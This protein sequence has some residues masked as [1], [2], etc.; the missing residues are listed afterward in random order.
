MKTIV[1]PAIV[2]VALAGGATI[3]TKIFGGDSQ[4]NLRMAPVKRGDLQISIG[5]SGVVQPEEVVDIG[6]QVAGKIN[7]LGADP[8]GDTDSQYK[9]KTV[10]F[11]TPVNEGMIL[12]TIDDAV[13][14]AVRDQNKASLDRAKAD[15]LQ[16]QAKLDQAGQDWKRAERLFEM[17][18]PV[19]EGLSSAYKN[20]S[21]LGSSLD[22]TSIKGISESDYDLAKANFEVARANVEVG[23]SAIEQAQASLQ[24]AETN[25]GY[26]VIKSPVNGTVIARRVNIGQTVVSSLNA[27]SLFLIAKDLT[28]MQVWASVNEADVGRVKEGMPVRFTVDKVPDEVFRGRVG[29]IRLNATMTQNVVT[30]TVVISA[31]NPDLKLFPYLTADVDFEIDSRTDVL[32]VPNAALAWQPQPNLIA[33]DI[34]DSFQAA[35]PGA[36]RRR[37]GQAGQ[38]QGGGQRQAQASGGNRPAGT[39][40]S[41]RS[42]D[43]RYVWI[44]DDEFVRPIEV[45][46]GVT[47][48]TTTEVSGDE[49]KEGMEVVIGEVRTVATRGQ[50]TNPFAPQV[51]RGGR[52]GGG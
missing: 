28:K 18:P 30:Y 20:R 7:S 16:M 34:R 46:V 3:F 19:S 26:T 12:A 9:D 38:G 27:P 2:I 51:L 23:K 14:R 32:L 36:E 6:A 15:L 22:L 49:L 5:A 50:E 8:R 47:D 1:I 45:K 25:L 48:G 24:M 37:E 43:K 52:R 33:P 42:R 4:P 11:N 21:A 40:R 17:K 39:G 10:D 13:Y 41:G 29:Q 44:K 31:D 35:S